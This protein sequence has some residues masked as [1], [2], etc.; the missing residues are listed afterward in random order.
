MRVSV[1]L[2]ENTPFNAVSEWQHNRMNHQT[3]VEICSQGAWDNHESASAVIEN[4]SPDHNSR[5]KSNVSRP[6][7][8]LLQALNWA[9]S[10]LQTAI[11]DTKAE[12]AFIRKHN[13]SALRPPMS[14]SL[15]PLTSQTAVVW[16]QWNARYRTSGSELP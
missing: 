2:L 9:P 7:T 14:S 13:R 15:T 1:S 6:Q 16:S 12:P 11:T 4:C 10:N 3:D 5:C 8:Y